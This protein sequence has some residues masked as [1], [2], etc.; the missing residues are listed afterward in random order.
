MAI[1]RGGM[2]FGMSRD[3]KLMDLGSLPLALLEIPGTG[4][5]NHRR[6]EAYSFHGSIIIHTSLGSAAEH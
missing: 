1:K 4:R 5:L 6:N 2:A 3:A